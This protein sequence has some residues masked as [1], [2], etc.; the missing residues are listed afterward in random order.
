MS[1]SCTGLTFG[2]AALEGIGDMDFFGGTSFCLAS[3]FLVGLGEGSST[4]ASPV[5]RLSCGIFA[6]KGCDA[7]TDKE[8]M[9]P[10]LGEADFIPFFP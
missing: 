7:G 1:F 6:F 4:G 2:G 3:I 9:F 8:E 5:R 10:F